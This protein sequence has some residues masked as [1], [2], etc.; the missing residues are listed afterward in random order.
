M[1][2]FILWCDIDGFVEVVNH[3]FPPVS[4]SFRLYW[5]VCASDSVLSFLAGAKGLQ[6]P[7]QSLFLNFHT[8]LYRPQGPRH[9]CSKQSVRAGPTAWST[10][11]QWHSVK[12]CSVKSTRLQVSNFKTTWSLTKLIISVFFYW[13]LIGLKIS[14]QHWHSLACSLGFVW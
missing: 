6:S 1:S 13:S 8:S 5:H 12:V 9:F 4:V 11:H 3:L 10:E 2:C 7:P 14:L